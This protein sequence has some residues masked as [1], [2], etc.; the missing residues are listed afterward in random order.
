[1]NIIIVDDTPVSVTVLR[2][3][4]E[5][6]PGCAPI[7]FTDPVQALA[8]CESNDP[9]LVI[10]DY[11]M[12][13]IDGIEFTRR[14]RALTGKSEIPVLMVTASSDREL[15]HRALESG[16]NDFLNK[17][18]DLVELQ[19]RARNMLALSA[20]YKKLANR[21]LLLAEEVHKATE[22]IRARELETLLCLGRAS[23][24]RDPE[25][26]EHIM[27]MSNYS[28]LIARQLGLPEAECDLL[29]LAAPMHDIGKI[30]TPDAILLKPG[31]LT[32]DEWIVMKQ[33]TTVGYE[34]LAASSSPVL[35]A[36]SEIALSHH[37]KFDGS[38]YP[39]G[40]VG[41]AIPLYGRIVAVADVFDALTSARPYKPA[42]DTERAA[43]LL[44]E[45]SGNHFDPACVEAFFGAWDAVMAIK[46]RYR[47]A[48]P[49]AVAA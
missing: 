48:H 17:P 37:E 14:F 4:V 49:E 29:L 43:N 40:L 18:F 8:W 2:R 28:R 46:N 24:Q 47:E 22:Q 25:T 10:V 42:W 13:Q 39:N 34:I 7:G 23:E 20:S 1:M 5:K 19:A 6:M 3:L 30:G 15:R 32:P 12:P 16:I 36:A 9:D 44:R 38:G 35:R 33:H 45:G 31:K 11:Q 41:Q 27:R 21:A 26:H